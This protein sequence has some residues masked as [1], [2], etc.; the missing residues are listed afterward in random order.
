LRLP[1]WGGLLGA[2]RV[3]PA[4]WEGTPWDR[5]ELTPEVDK[6][7]WGRPAV[8]TV[9]TVTAAAAPE[10]A[11]APPP[12]PSSL[13]RSLEQHFVY[14]AFSTIAS[15]MRTDP[16]QARELLLGFADLSRTADRVGTPEIPLADELAAVKAYLAIEKA[17]FGRRLEQ[18]LT[19]ADGLDDV[20]VAPLQ[21]LVAV[22]DTVQ[23]GIEPR[24][25]GGRLD[26][27]AG[28]DGAGGAVVE[29][30]DVGHTTTRVVLHAPASTSV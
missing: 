26:V 1:V 25:E 7:V 6:E 5:D 28:P 21:V 17:R 20:V 22:R 23:K 15:L 16:K 13:N 2:D 3:D 27:T 10:P 19:V 4:E 9:T 18:S 14:N 24:P 30:V 12:A 29:V 11:P 8:T